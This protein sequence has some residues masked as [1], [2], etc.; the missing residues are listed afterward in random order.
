MSI[1]NGDYATVNNILY[2]DIRVEDARH[3]LIDLGV[4]ISQY[5]LDRHPDEKERTQRYLHGAWDGVQ[6]AQFYGKEKHARYRGKIKDITFRNI[7]IIDG[8]I[9]FSLIC[10]YD[11][12]HNIENITFENLRFYGRKIKNP[13]AAKM[14]L[15]FADNVKFK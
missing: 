4:F 11:D 9:P 15:D 6:D 3:K 12:E 14:Y 10:G 2:D 8:K 7:Q 1:H 13:N 5:S